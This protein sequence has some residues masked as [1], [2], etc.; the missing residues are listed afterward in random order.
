[1]VGERGPVSVGVSGLQG[2]GMVEGSWEYGQAEEGKG[3]G[4][5]GFG[6]C[7]RAGVG[8]G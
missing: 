3:D 6:G 4:V 5:G 8:T 2:E 1:M 7:G